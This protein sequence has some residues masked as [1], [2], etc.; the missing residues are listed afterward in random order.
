MKIDTTSFKVPEL[1]NLENFLELLRNE[2][3]EDIE[4]MFLKTS[5]QFKRDLKD[6]FPDK[7]KTGSFKAYFKTLEEKKP[8]PSYLNDKDI[9]TWS[10]EDFK[11]IKSL[12]TAGL[13]YVSLI[14]KNSEVLARF[15]EY[16]K[17]LTLN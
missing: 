9:N 6:W 4:G 13:V 5:A 11:L 8:D 2:P 10:D 16:T 15:K 12:Y 7:P 3:I 17:N 14:N 1:Y